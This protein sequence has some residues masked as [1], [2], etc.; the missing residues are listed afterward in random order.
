MMSDS[1]S[2]VSDSNSP[3]RKKYKKADEKK[4]ATAGNVPAMI[5]YFK[6]LAADKYCKSYYDDY[7]DKTLTCNCL[8][9]LGEDDAAQAVVA[10][11]L[12][13]L[14]MNKAAQQIYLMTTLQYSHEAVSQQDAKTKH[15]VFILPIDYSAGGIDADTLAFAKASSLQVSY[16]ACHVHR[17]HQ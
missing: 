12:Q 7:K 15:R 10:G 3:I 6:A 13:F 11:A 14:K 1:E 5:A 4:N 2:S 16:D 17:V 8:E 9:I